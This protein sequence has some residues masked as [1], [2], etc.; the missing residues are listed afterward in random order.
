MGTGRGRSPVITDRSEWHTPAAAMR[1]TTSPGP[2][3]ASSSGEAVR[4]P[5]KGGAWPIDSSTAASTC[6]GANLD[7]VS[8]PPAG[9]GSD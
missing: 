3:S 6:M 5:V 2:G 8:G 7:A 9:R 1:T 4:A